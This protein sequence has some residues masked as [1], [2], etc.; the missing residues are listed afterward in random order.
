MA[1]GKL[2]TVECQMMIRKPISEVFQAFMDPTVTTR[3][4]FTKSS[5][6]LEVGKHYRH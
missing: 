4:W 2:P 6:G 1:K 5:G 3:F